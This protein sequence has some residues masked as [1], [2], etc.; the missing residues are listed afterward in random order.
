[1]RWHRI[2]KK[3]SD[4][5]VDSYYRELI[6]DGCPI[7]GFYEME[8]VDKMSFLKD[9]FKIVS[10]HLDINL[11][12]TKARNIDMYVA[13]IR[14]CIARINDYD[15]EDGGWQSAIDHEDIAGEYFNFNTV[16]EYPKILHKLRMNEEVTIQDFIKEEKGK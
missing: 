13:M 15:G 5:G 16:D 10:Y 6:D 9:L 7:L 11:K 2:E 1:M 4:N 3:Y 14:D 12:R 8:V